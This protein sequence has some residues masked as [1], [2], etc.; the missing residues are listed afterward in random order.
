MRNLFIIPALCVAVFIIY[1]VVVTVIVLDFSIDS[2][3]NV[4]LMV[5]AVVVNV[6]G[7]LP[8]IGTIAA[9]AVFA[10]DFIAVLFF[11]MDFFVYIGV[12]VII[13]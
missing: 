10:V 13:S 11:V 5:I 9:V 4:G 6:I 12:I 1:L 3:V 8:M 7:K 2:I